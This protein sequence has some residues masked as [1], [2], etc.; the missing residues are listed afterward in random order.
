MSTAAILAKPGGGGAWQKI[1]GKWQSSVSETNSNIKPKLG[2]IK[3]E[4]NLDIQVGLRTKS[5]KILTVFRVSMENFPNLNKKY[6]E[7]Y[8]QQAYNKSGQS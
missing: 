5:C 6:F 1:D 8:G 2:D 4:R 7:D 3:T